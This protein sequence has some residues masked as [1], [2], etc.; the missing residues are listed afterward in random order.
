M[1]GLIRGLLRDVLS[2][3]V[4]RILVLSDGEI[5]EYDTPKNLLGNPSSHFY[6][7]AREAR[8]I[9]FISSE[10]VKLDGARL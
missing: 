2:L 8:L 10:V 5:V 9:P 4:H 6:S 1:H 7:M 3:C